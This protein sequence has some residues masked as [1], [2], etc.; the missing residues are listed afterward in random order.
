MLSALT[1]RKPAKGGLGP[2]MTMVGTAPVIVSRGM[3]VAL[4]GPDGVGKTSQT[5]ELTRTLQAQF[6]C[7]AVYLGSGEGG[8]RLR[9]IVR[10]QFHKWRPRRIKQGSEANA[11]APRR[12]F[13]TNHS[14]TTALAG[15]GIAL[16]RYV[17][18]RRAMRLASSGS[19]VI[20]DR[21]PQNLRPGMFDGP[22]QLVPSASAIVRLLSRFER[23]LYRR[24]Q[25]RTPD[26][27]IHLVTDYETSNAR[28]PGDRS[29]SEFDMR[30][31]LMHEMRVH[32]PNIKIV[33]ARKEFD[34]V[35]AELSKCVRTALE[36]QA[37]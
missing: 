27:M 11:P 37:G 1:F 18:L 7:T 33:D 36:Q 34:V 32:D 21:W 2:A 31:A 22:L 19:I 12:E 20:S 16:E 35:T 26:L 5:A 6:K 29:R 13:Y 10:R 4:V 9:R 17:T 3:V 25:K 14:V 8:W 24:M 30:M 23:D 28:K 15:L